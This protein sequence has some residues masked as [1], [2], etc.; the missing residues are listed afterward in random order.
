MS[1]LSDIQKE[2]TEQ[3]EKPYR[4]KSIRDKVDKKDKK[5]KGELIP[6]SELIRRG[7]KTK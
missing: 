6:T 3:F 7:Q 5:F 1:R 2:L 4:I